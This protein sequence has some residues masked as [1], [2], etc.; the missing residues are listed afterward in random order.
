[1]VAWMQLINAAFDLG[2]M[3]DAAR[4]DVITRHTRFTCRASAPIVLKAMEEHAQ[5]LGGTC[6]RRGDC[7]CAR[8]LHVDVNYI[9]LVAIDVC[10]ITI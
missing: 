9:Q 6:Q 2:A 3:F 7:R 1:M 5:S 8:S 4:G 10:L